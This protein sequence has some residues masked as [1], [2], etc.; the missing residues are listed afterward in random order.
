M[1][2]QQRSAAMA[3]LSFEHLDA[4][5][6]RARR[7]VVEDIYREAYVEAIQSGAPF[8]DPAAFMNRFDA[9]TAPDRPAGFSLVLAV[10]D[11]HPIGQ[12]WGWPLHADTAWWGG[13][14]LD[15]PHDIDEF[16]TEDGTRTFALSE[17]MVS[18][19]LTGRG[20]AR[21]LHD[22]LLGSRPEQRGTLLVR[23]TNTRA[24]QTYLRWGWRRVGTLQPNWPAAPLFD[25]LIHDLAV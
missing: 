11:E 12:A 24:Y 13:L 14:T 7:A 20:I 10:V 5:E 6:A 25:V 4:R 19:K 3:G 9:Y 17:I 8:A 23:P 15:D 18:A 1:T 22:E 21:A 2:S 16:T